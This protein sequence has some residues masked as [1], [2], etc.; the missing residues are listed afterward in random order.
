MTVLVVE[1]TYIR[2]VRETKSMAQSQL[3][4]QE[5]YGWLGP[6]I[7]TDIELLMGNLFWTRLDSYE[8]QRL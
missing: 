6:A 5:F 1:A 4:L 3:S 7:R 2:P 8:D